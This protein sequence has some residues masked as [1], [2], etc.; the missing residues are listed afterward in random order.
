MSFSFIAIIKELTYKTF[1]NSL[2]LFIQKQ[3]HT[4]DMCTKIF[5]KKTIHLILSV[6]RFQPYALR[7]HETKTKLLD[8]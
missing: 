5:A 2:L 8:H 3:G 4:L 7:L 1:E 6:Y